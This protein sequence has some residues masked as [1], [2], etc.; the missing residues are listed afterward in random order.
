MA[1]EDNWNDEDANDND[2]DVDGV[3]KKT[4][5]NSKAKFRAFLSASPL[6][7]RRN[8]RALSADESLFPHSAVQNL[9]I[10]YTGRS[11]FYDDDDDSDAQD[12][13]FQPTAAQQEPIDQKVLNEIGLFENL[14]DKYFRAKQRTPR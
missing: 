5:R 2:S 4:N 12:D 3:R 1:K 9:R 10:L 14:I 6:F 11:E 13:V 8:H 7:Q